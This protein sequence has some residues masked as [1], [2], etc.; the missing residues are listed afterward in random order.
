M[1][2]TEQSPG[3]RKLLPRT[4]RRAQLIQAAATAFAREGYASTGLEDVALQAG[5]TRAII[6][7]HFASKHELYLAVL[8]DT[9]AR[10]RSRIGTPDAYTPDTVE[11]LVAAACENPDGFRLLF[12]HAQHEPEFAEFI[13]E[14]SRLA[15][16]ITETYLR[17][18]QNDPAHR[19]WLAELI[20]KLTIE[21]TLSW[22]EAG[23]PTSEAKLVDT[24]RGVTRALSTG[25]GG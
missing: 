17:Q 6:Y 9:Q 23:R 10:M 11:D 4:E 7:R 14:R 13:E 24:I 16:R 8:D 18:A 15:T 20:P 22:L 25:G 19:Q 21:L 2:Q 12:R 3:P 5:V 1:T